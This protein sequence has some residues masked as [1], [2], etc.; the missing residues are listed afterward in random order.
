MPVAQI[1]CR[2]ARLMPLLDPNDLNARS[3]S[4]VFSGQILPQIEGIS[5]GRVNPVVSC[6]SLNLD[7]GGGIT[8]LCS[9]PWGLS[10]PLPSWKAV[11]FLTLFS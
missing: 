5:G 7:P 9:T 11:C 10:E 8:G 6:Q 1:G 3:S 4:S 2:G